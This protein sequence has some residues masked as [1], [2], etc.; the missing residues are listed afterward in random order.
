MTFRTSSLIHLRR[1]LSGFD[2][3]RDWNLD[4]SVE[5]GFANLRGTTPGGGAPPAPEPVVELVGGKIPVVGQTVEIRDISNAP[6]S[7]IQSSEFTFDDGS[8]S[9]EKQV[10]RQLSDDGIS[11]I[12]LSV[13]N[14][15]GN[16]VSDTKKLLVTTNA[17]PGVRL[18]GA[19][20]LR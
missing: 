14:I 8:T 11:E 10:T 2:F 15:E 16:T 1:P 7:L 9:Q 5:D 6:N 20:L 13:T 19:G 4:S 3:N 17:G 12:Q 18:A